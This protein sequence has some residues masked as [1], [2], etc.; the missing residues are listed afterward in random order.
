MAV[1]IFRIDD[2]NI[3]YRHVGEEIDYQISKQKV[4]EIAFQNGRK[5]IFSDVDDLPANEVTKGSKFMVNDTTKEY[6]AVNERMDAEDKLFITNSTG[7]PII[8][9][10]Y[11]Q[12][13]ETETIETLERNIV[14]PANNKP[15]RVAKIIKQGKLDHYTAFKIVVEGKQS[16]SFYSVVSDDNLY[17]TLYQTSK[18]ETETNTKTHEY[19]TDSTLVIDFKCPAYGS[20]L[21][22]HLNKEISVQVYLFD[23][24]GNIIMDTGLLNSKTQSY[25]FDFQKIGVKA[26]VV[27]DGMATLSIKERKSNKHI[28]IVK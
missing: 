15:F 26:K 7:K 23:K 21:I 5:E 13:N 28:L 8:I 18:V 16:C 10:I 11:G 19:K 3:Y 24:D 20:F 17:V 1:K 25:K 9:S 12:H 27:V 6:V 4:R 14:I 2:D 22:Q